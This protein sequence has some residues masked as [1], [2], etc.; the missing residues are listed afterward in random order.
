MPMS[1]ILSSIGELDLRDYQLEECPFILALP[2]QNRSWGS[3]NALVIAALVEFGAQESPSLADIVTRVNRG[4]KANLSISFVYKHFSD[5]AQLCS[6]LQFFIFRLIRNEFPRFRLENQASWTQ[7]DISAV[8]DRIFILARTHSRMV[9]R[10]ILGSSIADLSKNNELLARWIAAELSSLARGQ[11]DRPNLPTGPRRLFI[12][13]SA[14]AAMQT[15]IVTLIEEREMNSDELWNECRQFVGEQAR[16]MIPD[17]PNL[18]SDR[19]AFDRSER[20]LANSH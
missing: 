3:L 5:H 4:G 7:H 10:L 11:A 1:V 13:S 9:R 18:D 15:T 6:F 19:M 14:L 12:V 16:A 17:H 20:P 2:K 8:L